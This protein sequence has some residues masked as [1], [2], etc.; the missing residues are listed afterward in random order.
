MDGGFE[1]ICV[2][3]IYLATSGRDKPSHCRVQLQTDGFYDRVHVHLIWT[4]LH[5]LQLSVL[6]P[7]LST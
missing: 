5:S 3:K 7:I 4:T 6:P 2:C 1:M